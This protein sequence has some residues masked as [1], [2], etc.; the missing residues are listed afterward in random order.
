MKGENLIPLLQCPRTGKSLVRFGEHLRVE[1]EEARGAYRIVNDVAVLIDFSRSVL[2]ESSFFEESGKS[3]VARRRY[4]GLARIA[5]ALVSPEKMVTKQ[6]MESFVSRLLDKSTEEL[7]VLVVGGG[8]VGQGMQR[9][10]SEKRIRAVGFD[11]YFSEN[12][13]FVADAHQIPVKAGSFDGVVVQAVLEHVADPFQ[14]VAEIHRVLKPEGM[15]YAETPFLQH[16]HEGAYDFMRF[17]ERGHRYLFKA[18]KELNSGA[19]SGPGTQMLWAIDY[20][21]RSVF[22]SRRL[23]K[24]AK[25]LAFWLVYFD[26]ITPTSYSIDAASGVFFLGEKSMDEVT[27]RELVAGYK[28]AQ[29]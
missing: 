1:G 21:V 25:L 26:R 6:N 7:T 20:F 3:V 14:V 27:L 29:S 4:R 16:V 2:E 17:T 19:T 9:L 5:K 10:Y 15:V 13:S 24:L 12:V 23:G 22:R 11:I 18:F 28:G 8:S